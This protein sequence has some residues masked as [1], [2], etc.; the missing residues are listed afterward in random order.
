M[1]IAPKVS[2]W[3]SASL[4]SSILNLHPFGFYVARV[5]LQLDIT[6]DDLGFLILLPLP[7]SCRDVLL[8]LVCLCGT[9]EQTQGFM[10]ARQTLYQLN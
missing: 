4:L 7:P 3:V 1:R 9:K 10:I 2:Y 8:H 6:E 5:D